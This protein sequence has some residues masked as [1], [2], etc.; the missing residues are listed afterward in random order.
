MHVILEKGLCIKKESSKP[1]KTFQYQSC[2]S[3]FPYFAIVDDEKG[4]VSTPVLLSY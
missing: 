2:I 1:F 3:F 4:D